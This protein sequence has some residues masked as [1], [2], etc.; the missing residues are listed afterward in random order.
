MSF[1]ETVWGFGLERLLTCRRLGRDLL[2]VA[3]IERSV[4]RRV[5]STSLLF[6]RVRLQMPPVV[7]DL[8]AER[9]AAH[10]A[11]RTFA[12]AI[13][14]R[15]RA[16]INARSYSEKASRIWRIRRPVGPSSSVLSPAPDCTR[17]PQVAAS[18]GEPLRHLALASMPRNQSLRHVGCQIWR[19]WS[20]PQFVSHGSQQFVIGDLRLRRLH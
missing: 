5:T 2:N 19:G 13:A 11:P 6:V 9:H 1:P 10:A 18:G 15:T 16:R 17:A 4:A 14:A 8:L 20:A 7:R 12:A 3:M